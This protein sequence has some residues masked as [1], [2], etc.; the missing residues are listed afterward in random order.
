M[1]LIQLAAM[2]SQLTIAFIN[3]SPNMSTA[4]PPNRLFAPSRITSLPE[5]WASSSPS[6]GIAGASF[7]PGQPHLEPAMP[8][9]LGKCPIHMACPFW[10]LM[11]HPSGCHVLIHHKASIC[12]SWDFGTPEGFHLGPAF[13]HYRFYQVLTKDSN[14]VITTDVVCFCHHLLLAHSITLDD[15][16]LHTIHSIPATIHS[17]LSALTTSQIA[18]IHT[19]QDILHPY[20]STTI[21]QPI[22]GVHPTFLDTGGNTMPSPPGVPTPHP[23]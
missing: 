18:A 23:N 11:L 21:P 6:H 22:G 17:T 3:L 9:Y 12:C 5:L 1:R 7:P 4:I 8:L 14:A 15:K 19:L 10:P 13:H 2:Q 16:L 20:M